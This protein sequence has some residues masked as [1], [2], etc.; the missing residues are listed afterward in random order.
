MTDEPRRHPV[1]MILLALTALAIVPLPFINPQPTLWLGIPLWLWWSFGW[2]F[3][4]S[5]LTAWG[6]LRYWRDDDLE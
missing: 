1:F 2:T 5:C 6:I 4:L 3:V